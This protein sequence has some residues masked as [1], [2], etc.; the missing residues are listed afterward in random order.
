MERVERGGIAQRRDIAFLRA[1]PA[2]RALCRGGEQRSA[3]RRGGDT[4]RAGI[5]L[6]AIVG[7]REQRRFEPQRARCPIELGIPAAE[8]AE[9]GR[10]QIG[11][12]QPAHPLLGV[13]EFVAAIARQ[14]LVGAVTRERH[15]PK[16]EERRVGT[17]CVRTCRSRWSPY[18]ATKTKTYKKKQ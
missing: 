16:S 18:H 7:E 12:E 14:R 6:V 11:R 3:Q 17:E 5:G 13:L 8:A 1:V 15:R 2:E 10:A 4:H 9:D